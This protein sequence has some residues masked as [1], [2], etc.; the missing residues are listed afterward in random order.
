MRGCTGL[1][2]SLCYRYFSTHINIFLF[3][4]G[5]QK[6]KKDILPLVDV[7]DHKDS[8]C[9]QFS[10]NSRLITAAPNPDNMSVNDKKLPP[11]WLQSEWKIAAL[12]FIMLFPQH[13]LV[14]LHDSSFLPSLLKFICKATASGCF[15]HCV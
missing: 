3:K 7:E 13:T 10:A 12:M 5:I 8:S 2:A 6:K 4:S 14:F 11:L 9:L 15:S 1:M